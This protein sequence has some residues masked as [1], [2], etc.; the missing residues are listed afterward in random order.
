MQQCS[1]F[2]QLLGNVHDINVLIDRG[3]APFALHDLKGC[4]IVHC[5]CRAIRSQKS[6]VKLRSTS[7]TYSASFKA[8]W[9]KQGGL[10]SAHKPTAWYCLSTANHTPSHRVHDTSAQH[11]CLIYCC[12]RILKPTSSRH[13]INAVI[14]VS[15]FFMACCCY[16]HRLLL[17]LTTGRRSSGIASGR[18]R[19]T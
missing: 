5:G 9:K 16:C 15:A 1:C 4:P 6:A 14:L 8:K 2:S 18:S 11:P 12:H 19:H 10:N 3:S 7:S 17:Q 13:A